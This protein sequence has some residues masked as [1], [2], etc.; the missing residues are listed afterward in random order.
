MDFSAFEEVV[1]TDKKKE[2]TAESK[3]YVPFTIPQWEK[4]E[5]VAG[6]EIRPKELRVM[7]QSIFEGKV[8]LVKPKVLAIY[9]EVCPPEDLKVLLAEREAEA[10]AAA[11]K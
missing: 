9:N 4:L 8:E 10:V 3:H 2:G 5:A 1:A 11:K 6:R 7:I